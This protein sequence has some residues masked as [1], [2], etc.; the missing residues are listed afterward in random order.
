M[1]RILV[2]EDSPTQAEEIRQML[3]NKDYEVEHCRNGEEALRAISAAAPHAVLTDLDMPVM[4]GL[5]LVEEIRSQYPQVPVVLMTAFGSEETAMKAL[6]RGAASYVPKK[7]LQRDLLETLEGIVALAQERR[8]RRRLASFMDACDSTFCIENDPALVMPVVAYVQDAMESVALIDETE[9]IRVGVALEEA[10]LN[11]MYRGNLELTSDQLRDAYQLDD[12]GQSY[13]ELLES[14]RRAPPYR[15]RR[16]H[17]EAIVSRAEARCSVRGDGIAFTA[18]PSPS[19][20]DSAVLDG[21]QDRGLMLINTFMDEV[22]FNDNGN[23][24]TMIKRRA[25]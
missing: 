14:R 1:A 22:T 17:V 21:D 23:E 2:V 12:G 7:Y 13:Y 24:I 15:D 10:I 11:A 16:V 4:D 20:N 19:P 3:L 5:E 9:R 18:S 8:E 6:Q 25:R